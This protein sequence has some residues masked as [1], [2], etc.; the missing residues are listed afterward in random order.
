MFYACS[1]SLSVPVS[2]AVDVLTSVGAF[3]YLF[4]HADTI[5]HAHWCSLSSRCEHYWEREREN[6]LCCACQDAVMDTRAEVAD[7]A[8]LQA[9]MAEVRSDAADIYRKSWLVVGHVEN[10]PLVIDVLSYVSCVSWLCLFVKL[11]SL[12]DPS[13]FTLVTPGAWFTKYLMIYHTI[14]LSLL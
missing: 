3:F 14:I 9:A 4:I 11:H 5:F 13:C 6:W 2:V 10:N 12:M 7:L 1:S 8:R